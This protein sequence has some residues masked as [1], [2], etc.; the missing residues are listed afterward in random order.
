MADEA[1]EGAEARSASRST[2]PGVYGRENQPPSAASVPSV[3][4]R[5]CRPCSHVLDTLPGVLDHTDLRLSREPRTRLEG[6]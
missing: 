4:S 2:E 6:R 1:E 5:T 3:M